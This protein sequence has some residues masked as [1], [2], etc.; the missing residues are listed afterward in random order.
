MAREP[1]PAKGDVGLLRFRLSDAFRATPT[2]TAIAQKEREAETDLEESASTALR[3][4]HGTGG[5]SEFAG[6]L[7]LGLED[8]TTVMRQNHKHEQDLEPNRWDSEEV[9]RN[10]LGN[11]IVD[12]RLPGLRRRAVVADHVLPDRGLGYVEAQFQQ[13]TVDSRC[14]RVGWPGSPFELSLAPQ[15]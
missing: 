3:R 1:W 9:H 6:T 8:T 14:P 10:Q 5:S 13:L 15:R 7:A 12:K 2:T 4:S 11:V